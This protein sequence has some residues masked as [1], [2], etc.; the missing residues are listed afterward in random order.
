[1]SS[2]GNARFRLVDARITADTKNQ[3]AQRL[4]LHN[5]YRF[6]NQQIRS[7][8]PLAALPRCTNRPSG[9]PNVI[10]ITQSASTSMPRVSRWLH[11]WTDGGN[12]TLSVARS[13]HGYLLRFP[14]LCDFHL[15][16]DSN[17]IHVQRRAGMEDHT[18]EHLLV[19]QAL[20][21]LLAHQGELIAHASALVVEGR[22]VLFLGPSGAGK[23][24]LAALM[25][26]AGHQV[27]S[28]DCTLLQ[29]PSG[30]SVTALSTYPSLRLLPDSLEHIIQA[31]T[32]TTAMASYSD[33]RRVHVP[34]I[35][36]S[37]TRVHAMYVLDATPSHPDP[38]IKAR[39]PSA[40]CLDLIRH[41]FQ[42]D[43]T[44]RARTASLLAHCGEL[45]RR[46]PA[47]SLSYMH[48]FEGTHT[49]VE[50]VGKHVKA[51]PA[52]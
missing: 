19:D 15:D 25:Q 39:R 36:A 45:A 41:S 8:I 20:P 40:A 51:L 24:T 14:R 38:V 18:L 2:R 42:L 46:V 47:F 22:T 52:H 6:G 27:L 23:S 11:R 35:V 48:A 5:H 16:P 43:V 32:V 17:S 29:L 7:D 1:M 34:D 28:D 37:P 12:T 31:N 21:R 26:R 4:T 49:L 44:D 13:E 33:K 50:T 10:H 3:Q 30:D 9:E